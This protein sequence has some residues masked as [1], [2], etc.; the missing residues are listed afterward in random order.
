MVKSVSCCCMRGSRLFSDLV[1]YADW[2]KSED[3]EEVS[4]FDA[5]RWYSKADSYYNASWYSYRSTSYLEYSYRVYTY[6]LNRVGGKM[7]CI[8]RFRLISSKIL[9]LLYQAYVQY[10]MPILDY[11]DVVWVPSVIV[12]KRHLERLYSRIISFSH[13]AVK[14]FKILH[15]IASSYLHGMFCHALEI[16]GRVGKNPLRLYVPSIR[17]T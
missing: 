11:Y 16:S 13:T 8:N 10:I 3:W 9:R 1:T 14:V 7:Y 17:T 15:E 2:L 12:H 5:E 6:V 4:S